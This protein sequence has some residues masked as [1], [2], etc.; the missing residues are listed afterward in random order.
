MR[1]H[2]LIAC[3]VLPLFMVQLFAA[4]AWRAP[5]K[6]QID[7]IYPQVETLYE[8][9]HRNPELSYHE[10][11][12]AA[13]IADQLRK[14]GFAVTTGVGGTGVVGI[15][16]NGAGPTV[17]IRAELDALPVPEKTGLTYASH[18]TTH[19]DRG[20]EVPVMHACGHDLHM[21]IGIGTATLLAQNQNRWHGTFIY[22][23]QPAEERICGAKAMLKDGLFTRFPKPDFAVAVHDSNEYPSGTIAYTPG[24][25]AANS[26]SVDVTIFGVGGHG[27][28]PQA[29]VDPIVLAARTIVSWQTIVARE[30]DPQD[31]AV[32]TVG[33]IHGGTKHNIIPDEVHLQLTVRSYKDDVRKHLLAAIERI[34]DAEAASANAPKKPMVQ[35]TESVG[36][37]YNDPQLNERLVGVLKQV[38]GENNV[39][40]GHPIMGSDD[41]AEYRQFGVPS[42]MLALGA[43]EPAKFA[44]AQKTGENLPGPHSPFFA[45]DREPSLKTGIEAETAAVLEL[46]GRP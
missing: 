1:S 41:F 5:S 11:K 29:T 23:G 30:I 3:T 37:V 9:L 39:V 44:A 12:T 13:T 33:S 40:K 34:A 27:S 22:V 20:V 28:R 7:G 31:P 45:P 43:V 10:E 21:S 38:L 6:A 36:A 26:D 35:V 4:D 46:L 19:D 25:S 24:F 14:L 15:L 42:A 16:K 8:D 2:F 17:M 32:I 18:V